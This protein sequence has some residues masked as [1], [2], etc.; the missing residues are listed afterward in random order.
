MH[1][2]SLNQFHAAGHGVFFSGLLANGDRDSFLW[3]FDCGSKRTGRLANLVEDLATNSN[4]RGIDM[5]CLSHFDADHVNGLKELLSRFS[6]VD[7]LVLP[8]CSFSDRLSM[9]C[10]ID[11]DYPEAAAAMA[12]SIDPVG[13]LEQQYP[14]VVKSVILVRGGESDALGEP[15]PWPGPEPVPPESNLDEADFQGPNGG[16]APL[17][18]GSGIKLGFLNGNVPLHSLDFEWEFMFYNKALPNEVAPKSGASL[19]TLRSDVLNALNPTTAGAQLLAADAGNLRKRLRACYEKHFGDSGPARNDISLCVYSAPIA[20]VKAE[21]CGWFEHPHSTLG[22]AS[23]SL[24]CDPEK[25]GLL[26]TGDISLDEGGRA[27]MESHYGRRR[28]LSL[29]V[30]QIPHH[31]SK[32]SWV[33]RLARK[34]FHNFSVFCVPDYDALHHHPHYSVLKDVSDLHPV[35]ASYSQSVIWTFHARSVS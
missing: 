19:A 7:L 11:P 4:R 16:Y 31:G 20:E 33:G 34:C 14:G 2:H 10:D 9:A 24:P 5:L 3:V 35:F 32:N 18:G 15:L 30:M 12:L 21:A 25:R 22:D 6:R 13:F 1:M 8:Y 23:L 27:A 17:R 29:H 28:W 26:M